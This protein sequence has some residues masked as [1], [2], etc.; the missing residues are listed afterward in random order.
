MSMC[1]LTEKDVADVL[2][3]LRTPYAKKGRFTKQ[4]EDMMLKAHVMHQGVNVPCEALIATLNSMGECKHTHRKDTHSSVH[5]TC[6]ACG[7]LLRSAKLFAVTGVDKRHRQAVFATG[8]GFLTIRRQQSGALEC[9]T[10]TS[11]CRLQ[12]KN[13]MTKVRATSFPKSI[14]DSL[15]AGLSEMQK[16]GKRGSAL[17]T[18]VTTN[19][20]WLLGPKFAK[21]TWRVYD[22]L[23]NGAYGLTF[24]VINQKT[25]KSKALKMVAE[26]GPEDVLTEF[27]MHQGLYKAG[28]APQPHYQLYRGRKMT[29][30]TKTPPRIIYGYLMDR[31]DK[32]AE[33]L[34]ATS[35]TKGQI[36]LMAQ[37]LTQ[38]I[39]DLRKHNYVHGDMHWGNI[40]I[41]K[42]QLR[43]GG[44]DLG[45]IDFGW[46][47]RGYWPA[48]EAMQLFRG[49]LMI[50]ADEL[51]ECETGQTWQW[52]CE[53]YVRVLR[54]LDYFRRTFVL[55]KLHTAPAWWETKPRELVLE[56]S[57]VYDA[58]EWRL[59]STKSVFALYK[60]VL[61]TAIRQARAEERRGKKIKKDE[62]DKRIKHMK[63]VQDVVQRAVDELD[64]RMD[65]MISLLQDAH[66]HT[67]Q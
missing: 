55:A 1:S 48:Y 26:L 51:A 8:D 11:D 53:N 3:S 16:A 12:L 32:N 31:I 20:N 45:L 35:Q 49:G 33:H 13:Y 64:E 2:T 10:E 54:R 23:G 41:T 18:R 47:Y 30:K 15:L 40:A 62:H 28:L 44:A 24:G 29:T 42:G 7:S 65:L 52:A 63:R 61:T 19:V 27:R 58:A 17:C 56:D 46:T 66:H 43:L 59:M 60:R 5:R 37:Q 6:E 34:V 36:K 50:L 57:P 21:T 14:K 67:L 9:I 25:G 22:V 39:L 38:V 4:G